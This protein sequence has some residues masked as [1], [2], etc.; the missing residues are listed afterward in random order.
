MVVF[1][2]KRLK[3]GEGQGGWV[4]GIGVDFGARSRYRFPQVFP[5][6]HSLK[7]PKAS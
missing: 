2:F 6:A 3:A 7:G 1:F 5:V 4:W